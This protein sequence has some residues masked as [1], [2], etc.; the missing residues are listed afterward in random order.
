MDNLIFLSSKTILVVKCHLPPLNS[1]V[2]HCKISIGSFSSGTVNKRCYSKD[3]GVSGS[4]F[5]TV[6]QFN[7][8]CFSYISLTD[9]YCVYTTFSEGVDVVLVKS[10]KAVCFLLIGSDYELIM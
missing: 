9:I 1:S 2:T 3:Y 8:H 6:Q 10:I 5:D 4:R 7:K